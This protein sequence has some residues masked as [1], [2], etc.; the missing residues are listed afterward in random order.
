MARRSRHAGDGLGDRAG[1]AAQAAGLLDAPPG[2]LGIAGAALAQPQ[3]LALVER[4]LPAGPLASSR[5]CSRSCDLEQVGDVGRGVLELA[6]LERP[7][8][9]VGEPVGLGQPQAELAL[10]QRG[11]RRRGHAEEAGGDLGV[12]QALRDGAAGEVEDLEVLVGGVQHRERVAVEDLGERREVD[13]ERVDQDQAAVPGELHQRDLRVVGA[14]A[15][16]LG[17]ERVRRLVAQRRR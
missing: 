8:Q 7:A 10:V 2:L 14:L 13:R 6:R 3:L 9:P 12:E 17:V 16:E 1:R 4:P 11:Q 15:V 5:L